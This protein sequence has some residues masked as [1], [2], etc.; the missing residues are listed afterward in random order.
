MSLI[1]EALRKARQEAAKREGRERGIP[2]G[3]VVPPKRWRSGPGL[4]LI[5]AIAL[6]AAVAGAAA[7]WWT[8]GRRA[9][10]E[11]PSTAAV[12]PAPATP[13]PATNLQAAAPLPD[14][15]ARGEPE[16]VAAHVAPAPHAT[17]ESQ[18][19]A[20][21]RTPQV[22][23]PT[24][25]TQPATGPL[26]AHGAEQAEDSAAAERPVT[27]QGSAERAPREREFVID[28]DLGHVK[29]HLDYVVYRPGSPF[30]GVNGQQVIIGS[31]I[32]GFQVE[33]IGPELVRLRDGRGT[34]VL[35]TH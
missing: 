30:A 19:L 17:Q 9:T 15:T 8:L 6:A 4:A 18:L 24:P 14:T 13:A 3:L 10:M 26:P 25:M 23:G 31:V 20:V 16:T 22:H 34:V 1:T 11:T 5:V 28:A 33:E 21:V 12:L 32:E 7:A 27:H 35:R 29:L 2:H